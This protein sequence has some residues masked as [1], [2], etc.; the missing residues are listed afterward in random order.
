MSISVTKTGPYFVS[1]EIKWSAMRSNCKESS[2]GSIS[3]SELFQNTNIRDI[4]P[5]VPHCTENNQVTDEFTLSSGK[6]LFSGNA[7]DWKASLM[8]NFVK[9]YTAN[10]SGIDSNL[11]LGL[12]TSSGNKGLDW[13]GQGVADAAGSVNG[14]Y[15][16]NIQKIINIT[17]SASSTDSGNNGEP[18]GGGIGNEK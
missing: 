18:G 2:S 10:Q 17:G 3:A 5:I 9:R 4:N 12:Y 6:Y 11:D 8:R 13:D 15:T 1:G 16:R 7:T 14:N